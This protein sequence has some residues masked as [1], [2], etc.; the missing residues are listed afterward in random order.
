MKK[1]DL[2]LP[3]II[4]VGLFLRVYNLASQS[5]WYDES[6]TYVI[7]STGFT[8]V[9]NAMASGGE[10]NPPLFYWMEYIV[11]YLL[12]AT[13]LTLRLIPFIAGVLAIPAIYFLGKEIGDRKLGLISA[14]FLAVSPWAVSYSQEARAYSLSVLF[15]IITLIYFFR[16]DPNCVKH[17]SL[18]GLFAALT[19]WTH[20]FTIIFVAPIILVTTQRGFMTRC[21][22]DRYLPQSA[23]AIAMTLPLLPSLYKMISTYTESGIGAQL[24]AAESGI[25]GLGYFNIFFAQSGYNPITM[26]F[27]IVAI[28]ITLYLFVFS[29]CTNRHCSDFLFVFSAPIIISVFLYYYGYIAVMPRYMSCLHPLLMIILG[30]FAL[31]F[32][33]RKGEKYVT[34]VAIFM[35]VLMSALSLGLFYIVPAKPAWE[36]GANYLRSVDQPGDSILIISG[37]YSWHPFRFYYDNATEG[38]YIYGATSYEGFLNYTDSKYF[39]LSEGEMKWIDPENKTYMWLDSHN[40][41]TRQFYGYGIYKAS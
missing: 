25:E 23:I 3:I 19:I 10:F 12:G 14:L 16:L 35:I 13:N 31:S 38:T 11:T 27:I 36:D 33:N 7:S 22:G 6:A 2:Y 20:F 28:A 15:F 41:T 37:H 32:L 29:D 4:I 17:V 40:A 9:W 39:I 34:F 8:G 24:V 21:L 26:V 1:E 5:L 18:F 30:I